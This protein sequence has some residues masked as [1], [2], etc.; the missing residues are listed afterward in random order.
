MEAKSSFSEGQSQ[1]GIGRQGLAQTC[2]LRGSLLWRKKGREMMEEEGKNFVNMG[3]P[4][5]H[6]PTDQL[7]KTERT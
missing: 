4:S 2:F 1:A 6:I 3:D 7:T 5:S